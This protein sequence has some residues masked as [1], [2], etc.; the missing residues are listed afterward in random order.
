[1]DL[2]QLYEKDVQ[3][4]TNPELTDKENLVEAALGLA[5]EA[6]GAAGVIKKWAT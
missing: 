5:S 2:F 6:G 1:M 4:T 3:R